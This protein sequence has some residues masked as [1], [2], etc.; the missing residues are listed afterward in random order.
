MLDEITLIVT[1]TCDSKIWSRFAC[2]IY[3]AKYGSFWSSFTDNISDLAHCE[4][5]QLTTRQVNRIIFI[6]GFR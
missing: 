3:D 6:I 4:R 1:N 2:I 5:E